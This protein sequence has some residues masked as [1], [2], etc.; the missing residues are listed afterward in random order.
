MSSNRKFILIEMLDY[1]RTLNIWQNTLKKNQANVKKL[2]MPD[3]FLRLWNYYFSYCQAGFLERH[4][5]TVQMIFA[6]PKYKESIKK[7]D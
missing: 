4:I 1:A 7:N 3:E 6:K 2:G 5:S